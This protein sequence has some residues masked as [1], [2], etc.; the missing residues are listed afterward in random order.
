[1]PKP[2]L[3]HYF[4]NRCLA[5]TEKIIENSKQTQ[6]LTQLRDTLLPQLISGRVRVPEGLG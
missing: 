3:I 4:E 2:K 1:M 5:N 6:T